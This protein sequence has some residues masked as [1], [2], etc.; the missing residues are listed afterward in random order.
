MVKYSSLYNRFYVHKSE[1]IKYLP[2]ESWKNYIERLRVFYLN[3]KHIFYPKF[4]VVN[5]TGRCMNGCTFCYAKNANNKKY[6]DEENLTSEDIGYWVDYF[7]PI[8]IF[9]LGGEPLLKLDLLG[10]IADLKE[11]GK[12]KSIGL[13][14]SL[15][16]V[17]TGVIEVLRRYNRIKIS[18]DNKFRHIDRAKILQLR[19]NIDGNIVI[20]FTASTED[21]DFKEIKDFAESNN[22]IFELG[23]A[24]ENSQI[25]HTISSKLLDSEVQDLIKSIDNEAPFKKEI[26][27]LYFLTNNTPFDIRKLFPCPLENSMVVLNPNKKLHCCDELSL[28]YD[29]PLYEK[30]IVD[31]NNVLESY[32][33]ILDK[34]WGMHNEKCEGCT[35][36]YFCKG[37]CLFGFQKVDNRCILIEQLFNNIFQKTYELYGI[38]PF[39][40]YNKLMD[41]LDKCNINLLKLSSHLIN[42][43]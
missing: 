32:F 15:P 22:M 20:K 24:I 16:F 19:K 1:F 27:M 42:I 33:G 12:V 35:V 7:K 13:S 10:A 21:I 37:L 6:T 18:V 17:T 40:R 3:N 28:T 38:V 9:V 34:F 31:S 5:V 25:I 23:W 29:S 39:L 4:L 43:A 41:G 30:F 36:R 11:A 8:H 14:S 26:N 2:A